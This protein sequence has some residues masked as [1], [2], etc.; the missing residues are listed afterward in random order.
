MHNRKCPIFL[1]HGFDVENTVANPLSL[2][3]PICNCFAF[4]CNCEI[5]ISAGSYVREEKEKLKGHIKDEQAVWLCSAH[6]K[7]LRHGKSA[8][9]PR[10]V[11]SPAM[12]LPQLKHSAQISNT[13]TGT[14]VF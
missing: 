14:A 6:G 4:S 10:I 7:K 8:A 2:I 9:P 13:Y 5:A 1:L 3:L 11:F 12:K